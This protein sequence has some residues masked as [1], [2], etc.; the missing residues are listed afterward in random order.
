MFVVTS[1][2]AGH[3]DVYFDVTWEIEQS[4]SFG[5]PVYYTKS[6]LMNTEQSA[7]LR[8]EAQAVADRLNQVIGADFDPHKVPE[9]SNALRSLAV[10]ARDTPEPERSQQL[11]LLVAKLSALAMKK[12]RVYPKSASHN[13]FIVQLGEKSRA[14]GGEYP[15]VG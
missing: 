12:Y 9:Y 15:Q 2:G 5:P 1:M 14:M 4:I 10:F 11:D 13:E 3:H 6:A 8:A 7:K